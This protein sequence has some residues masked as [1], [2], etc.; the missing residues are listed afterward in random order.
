MNLNNMIVISLSNLIWKAMRITL[1]P[2]LKMSNPKKLS[3]LLI[4]WEL[5]NNNQVDFLELII[6]FLKIV[7]QKKYY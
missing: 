3:K 1:E 7:Y 4:E 6:K 2:N 5:F